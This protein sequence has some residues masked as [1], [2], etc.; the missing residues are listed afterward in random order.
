MMPSRFIAALILICF[1]PVT[2]GEEPKKDPKDAGRDLRNMFLTT[3][4]EKAGIHPRVCAIA[5][6]WPIGEHIATVL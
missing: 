2:S 3:P 4:P 5:M 6:D 1:A